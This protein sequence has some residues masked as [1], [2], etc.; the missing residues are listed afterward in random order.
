MIFSVIIAFSLLSQG[1]KNSSNS[2]SITLQQADSIIAKKQIYT[3]DKTHF[4]SYLDSLRAKVS[5]D[6]NKTSVKYFFLSKKYAYNLNHSLEKKLPNIKM[7]LDYS[8]LSIKA[9]FTNEKLIN[10]KHYREF[11]KTYLDLTAKYQIAEGISDHKNNIFINTQWEIAK[12]ELSGAVKDFAL[13]HVIKHQITVFGHEFNDKMM[14]YFFKNCDNKSYKN[15]IDSLYNNLL[16][17]KAETE[18]RY[19]KITNN[20]TLSAYIYFPENRKNNMPCILIL[21]G[22]G[23]YIGHPLTRTC[24]PKDFNELGFVAVAIE[25]RIKGRQDASPV[26]GLMDAKAAIRWVRQNAG[27]LGVNPGK[28]L[29]SGLSSGGTLAALTAMTDG[30]EYKD[31]N[32]NNSSKPEGVI[33]WSGCVDVTRQG[34]FQYCLNGKDDCK[35]LSPTHLIKP[36]LIPFLIFQGTLDKYNN[37]TTHIEFCKKMKKAGN[38]CNLVLMQDTKHVEVYKQD[39]MDE[40]RAFIKYVFNH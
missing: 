23:W 17:L 6:E 5:A 9:D 3:L 31:E 10:N 14:N 26:K 8:A 22:G 29:I 27:E 12:N 32:L 4:I 15:T 36:G 39:M 2:Q 11:L 7:Y 30:Y 28:I 34:W 20:D 1:C 33:L 37:Y 24:I 18:E 38:Y 35:N 40:Y 21:H 16:E 19:Y 25:H 13:Y